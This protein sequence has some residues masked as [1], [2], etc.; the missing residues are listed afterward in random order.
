M[1]DL[2][3]Y[4]SGRYQRDPTGYKY[5]V[6]TLIDVEWTWKDQ[7][8]NSLLEN[9]AVKLGELNSYAKLVPSV[10]DFI[11][12][13]VT[14]EA[15]LSSRIEGT[16]TNIN[17][18]LLKESD[19]PEDRRNDW[20]EVRNYSE[21]LKLAISSL[22]KL[23]ISSRLLNQA[24]KILLEGVRGEKKMPGEFRRSQNWI[25]G[26]SPLDA[27]FVP[28]HYS[29]VPGL[30]SDLEKF[31]HNSEKSIPDLVK[32]AIA[33]YQFE[34]IHPYLDGNG[35]IGRLMITLLMVEKKLLN[36]P[37]LYLSTYF[38]RDKGLYYDNLTF[39][40]TRNDMSQWIKY[41]LVGVV[42][43]ATLASKQLSQVLE[44]KTEYQKQVIA[45]Y[46]RRTNSAMKLLDYLFVTPIVYVQEIKEHVEL[47]YKSANSLIKKFEEDG[48]IKKLFPLDRDRVFIFGKYLNLFEQNQG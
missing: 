26:S 41:F 35:R 10:S 8:I 17:E 13:H 21:A 20:R 12:L 38:E 18:A 40:R 36:A 30:I 27:K 23:P 34:T 37:L 44:L 33:H 2:D 48:I 39:V 24:H 9:A 43:I 42:E 5:F 31:I 47:S 4:E 22:E 25:G 6:P 45:N 1:I 46:G 29:L 32:I 3:K 11:E 28:P 19:I 14:K 7:V 15:V 16:Q